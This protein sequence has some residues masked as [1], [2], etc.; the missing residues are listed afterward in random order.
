MAKQKRTCKDCVLCETGAYG[1]T[2]CKYGSNGGA[3]DIVFPENKAC[4]MVTGPIQKT[5]KSVCGDFPK[6]NNAE[7]CDTCE[8][9]ENK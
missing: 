9:N 4:K 5:E 8:Y 7:G 6:C 3:G 1:L 2:R